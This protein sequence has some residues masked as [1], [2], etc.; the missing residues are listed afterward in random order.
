MVEELL[1][2]FQTDVH[3]CT[4]CK[5]IPG[6]YSSSAVAQFKEA[7]TSVT[8]ESKFIYGTTGYAGGESELQIVNSLPSP[9]NEHECR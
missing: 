6:S 4:H 2:C 9:T 8:L 1:K 5:K 3:S 7:R